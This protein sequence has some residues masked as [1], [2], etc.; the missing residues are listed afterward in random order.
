MFP[1]KLLATSL[2]NTLHSFKFNEISFT[3][4]Y[5]K[6]LYIFSFHFLSQL[7]LLLKL[8]CLNTID[9]TLLRKEILR[10]WNY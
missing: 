8:Y 2:E 9:K 7:W 4:I 1:L 5:L 10:K 3:S 6:A